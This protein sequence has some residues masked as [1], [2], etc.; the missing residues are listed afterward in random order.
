[1]TASLKLFFIG[2]VVKLASTMNKREF[3]F[4]LLLCIL[5]LFSNGESK[6]ANIYNYSAT[7]TSITIS[8]SSWNGSPQAANNP[9]QYRVCWKSANSIGLVCDQNESQTVTAQSYTIS[10]LPAGQSFKVRVKART[11]WPGNVID[12][13]TLDT[14][15]VP[16][17]GG[18][19]LSVTNA[20]SNGFD[21]QLTHTGFTNWN[22][23]RVCYKKAT[24]WTLP[25][26]DTVCGNGVDLSNWSASAKKGYH[27][28]TPSNSGVTNYTLAGLH[29]NC[30]YK[31]VAYGLESG[32]ALTQKKI[33]GVQ[34]DT[35]H[36]AGQVAGWLRCHSGPLLD[37]AVIVV[38]VYNEIFGRSADANDQSGPV[39]SEKTLGENGRLAIVYRDSEGWSKY[40][41][42][43]AEHYRGRSIIEGVAASHGE[44]AKAAY[45]EL[46][47]LQKKFGMPAPGDWEDEMA[48]LLAT[49][50]DIFEFW[51][52]RELAKA[53]LDL[54]SYIEGAQ[55]L[56]VQQLL[57]NAPAPTETVIGGGQTLTKNGL[58]AC[59]ANLPKGDPFL[60]LRSGPAA[61]AELIGRLGAGT[62]L[63][64]L[65]DQGKWIQVQPVHEG[66]K[67]PSGWVASKYTQLVKSREECAKLR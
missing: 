5:L 7:N 46:V 26:I 18:T 29:P 34:F 25:L 13:R 19:Q 52:A 31:V 1:M 8:W 10:N 62:V 42:A 36:S 50:P 38:G 23:I 65:G 2:N 27:E 33:G 44:K 55:G 61:S 16:T 28:I 22:N 67:E 35:E 63:T 4:G 9:K 32:I 20:L 54:K 53:G 39:V 59:V 60:N 51:Q 41:Q 66:M 21:L 56:Q 15:T 64:V 24:L 11:K 30:S 45:Q 6:A 14:V 3:L 37:D 49:S 57:Q 17:S 12:W 48:T 47:N 40:L 58:L 43:L